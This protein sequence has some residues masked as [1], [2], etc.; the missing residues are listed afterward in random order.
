MAQKVP[1]TGGRLDPSPLERPLHRSSHD[2]GLI[3]APRRRRS[4]T[5]PASPA[6]GPAMLEVLGQRV[7]H[8]GRDRKARSMPSLASSHR[9]TPWR[10]SMPSSRSRQTSLTRR[11]TRAMHKMIAR[12][13]RSRTDDASNEAMSSLKAC[14]VEVSDKIR[15]PVGHIGTASSRPF[16]PGPSGA[17]EPEERTQRRRHQLHRPWLIA[18]RCRADERNDVW[19]TTFPWAC[20]RPSGKRSSKNARTQAGV[21]DYRCLHEH[22]GLAADGHEE[23]P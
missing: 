14:R 19:S 20:T 7:S 18:T 3:G 23:R 6:V 22:P 8:L 13:R 15:S 10:Q 16:T 21:I 1:A 5:H 9:T 2:A 17:K 12:S 4:S 11:P